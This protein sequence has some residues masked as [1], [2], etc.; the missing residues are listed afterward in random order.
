MSAP[1]VPGAERIT[2]EYKHLRAFESDFDRAQGQVRQAAS[3]WILTGF[4]AFAYVLSVQNL[5]NGLP[6]AVLGVLVSWASTFGV[7][8]LWIIDQLVYQKLLHS[9]FVHGLYLEWRDRSLPRIRTKAYCDNLNVSF[10]LSLFYVVSAVAFLLVEFFFAVSAWSQ[11]ISAGL[12]CL[13]TVLLIIHASAIVG[14]IYVSRQDK[15]LLRAHGA[16]YPAAF[17]NYLRN[18]TFRGDLQAALAEP[19]SPSPTQPST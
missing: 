19:L 16:P 4:A 3:V 2:E 10:K 12:S 1:P 18:Q 8:I 11:G 9:V 7:M 5:P 6:P 13:I 14:M 15:N 17:Q